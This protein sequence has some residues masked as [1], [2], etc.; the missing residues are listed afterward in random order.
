MGRMAGPAFA[1]P[2]V[3]QG[4]RRKTAM[5]VAARDSRWPAYQAP[6]R[7][8]QPRASQLQTD[9]SARQAGARPL[10]CRPRPEPPCG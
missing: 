6:S 10:G 8:R 1:P 2:I 4:G 3:P 5:G 9:R 7:I